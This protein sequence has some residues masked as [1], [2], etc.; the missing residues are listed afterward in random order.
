MFKDEVFQDLKA[1][2]GVPIFILLVTS[3]FVLGR[4]EVALQLSLGFVASYAVTIATRAVYFRRRPD[5][6]GYKG[7]ISKIDASSFPS[8][9]SM[10]AGVLAS[11]L[12]LSFSNIILTIVFALASIGVAISRVVQK[13][14]FASDVVAGLII[15]V[16]IGC[17]IV[18]F[19]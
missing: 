9:H 14:H 7:F 6:E 1:L 5:K 15:G 3:F 12:S 17:S 4:R 11:V 8:L 18:Y 13:R 16:V 10:R 19:V 2:A